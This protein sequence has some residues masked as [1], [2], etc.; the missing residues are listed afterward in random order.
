MTAT[1]TVDS[2]TRDY[3]TDF[4]ASLV[5]GFSAL[6][7]S[8]SNVVYNSGNF[9]I[10]KV[11]SGTG[12]YADAYLKF[13]K[14][15]ITSYQHTLTVGTGHTASS[16]T[17][18]GAG[19]ECGAFYA[20][21]ADYT[22]RTI[23]ADDNSFG[24]VQIIDSSSVVIGSYGFVKPTTTTESAADICLVVGLSSI[25]SSTFQKL[26]SYA[27]IGYRNNNSNYQGTGAKYRDVGGTQ[28]NVEPYGN[29][30][31]VPALAR[32]GGYDY[33]GFA[34]SDAVSGGES[35]AS[36]TYYGVIPYSVA[37]GLESNIDGNL[38]V[39]PNVIIKSGGVPIGYNSNLAYCKPGL[40]PGDNIIVTAS[41]EE[42]KV[43]SSDGIAIRTV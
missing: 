5:A 30:R 29:L 37:F 40:N 36:S 39:M 27:T 41:S 6:G 16:S 12:T 38:P 15:G 13:E 10:F 23:K 18:S 14:N 20:N 3:Y 35:S 22:H 4:N 26:T 11:S 34:T 25:H 24:L 9:A 2:T 43:I 21:S 19:T 8:G 31:N 28:I 17:I 1:V 32:K 7:I 42:Y 33:E